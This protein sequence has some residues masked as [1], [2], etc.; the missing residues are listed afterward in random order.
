MHRQQR[1][2]VVVQ[3]LLCAVCCCVNCRCYT[4]ARYAGVDADRTSC[5]THTRQIC[6]QDNTAVALGRAAPAVRDSKRTSSQEPSY[7]S[8][9]CSSM[10]RL[11]TT[12]LRTYLQPQLNAAFPMMLLALMSLSLLKLLREPTPRAI[13]LPSTGFSGCSPMNHIRLM[14]DRYKLRLGGL[15]YSLCCL[16]RSNSSTLYCCMLAVRENTDSGAIAVL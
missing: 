13:L 4:S 11:D 8:S 5:H 10:L 15:C 3:Y 6:M 1:T 14:I 2:A 16:L 9:T 12:I 7:S